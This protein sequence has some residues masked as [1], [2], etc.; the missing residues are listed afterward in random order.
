MQLSDCLTVSPAGLLLYG[1]H[2]GE[3]SEVI[4]GDKDGNLLLRSLF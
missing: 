3:F 2:K 1:G 4:G